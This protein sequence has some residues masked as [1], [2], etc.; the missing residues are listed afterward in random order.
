MG[1]NKAKRVEFI[2]GY[3]GRLSSDKPSHFKRKKRHFCSMS[4]HSDFRKHMLPKEEQPRFGTGNTQEEKK[5]RV[6]A[7]STLNHYLRDKKIG[8]PK[9][10][11][12]GTKA[13]AHH[14]DYDKPL[15]VKW[16]CFKHH[17]MY[18]KHGDKIYENHELLNNG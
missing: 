9:C 10:E 15:E 18:H 8:R 3:C 12:C 1:N 2:C 17:R 6:K 5:K 7:R 4:C 16:L 13:E 11:L 14:D